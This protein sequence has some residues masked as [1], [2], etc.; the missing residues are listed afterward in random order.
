MTETVEEP[1][2]E[3]V[4]KQVCVPVPVEDCT[5]QVVGVILLLI[6]PDL[7]RW[8]SVKASQ[9]RNVQRLQFQ[10]KIR[11]INNS[12]NDCDLWTTRKIAFCSYQKSVQQ[13]VRLL[14]W[15]L[16]ILL[17]QLQTVGRQARR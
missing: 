3:I 5:Q 15:T 16:V 6:N 2:M 17:H 4:M 12:C 11:F 7:P 1:K 14:S 8:R 13:S 9:L 10:T